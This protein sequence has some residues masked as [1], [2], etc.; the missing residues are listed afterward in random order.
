MSAKMVR[1]SF[2]VPPSIRAD[3]DYVSS[4]LGIT[5]SALASEFLGLQLSDLRSL[6]EMVPDNPTDDD[7][8]RARGRSNELIIERLR[9]VRSIEGDLFD[10]RQM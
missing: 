4:R 1:V 9:N 5:K 7:M 8:V 10:D 6:L 2:T 3:L